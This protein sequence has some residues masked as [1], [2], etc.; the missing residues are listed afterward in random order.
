M[1][2]NFFLLLCVFCALS[3]LSAQRSKTDISNKS[4]TK[5][6]APAPDRA[7]KDALAFGMS[8]I[9]AYFRRD[10]DYV[11]SKFG[12]TVMSFESG[13]IFNVT[14][15]LKTE[16]CNENPLRTDIRVNLALY[17]EN[18]NQ[19]VMSSAEM[20]AQSPQAYQQLQMQTGDYF[21]DGSQRKSS[22][23]TSVFRASDAARFI[24]RKSGT[25]WVIIAI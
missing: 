15:D 23:S 25:S 7:K 10:C 4:T 17:T 21:F 2:R 11:W 24:I 22:T 18:Y 14:P 9:E 19:T 3:T 1:L 12:T 8:V 13:Q 16:F 20:L 5:T 6:E